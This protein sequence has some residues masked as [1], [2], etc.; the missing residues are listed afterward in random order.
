MPHKIDRIRFFAAIFSLFLK[1]VKYLKNHFPLAGKGLIVKWLKFSKSQPLFSCGMA[2]RYCKKGNW[3]SYDVF[4]MC[5]IE[6]LR[7]HLFLFDVFNIAL[8]DIHIMERC[9]FVHF[10]QVSSFTLQVKRESI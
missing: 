4:C 7:E 9:I 5:T 10:L 3:T 6:G 8:G 1:N 2:E